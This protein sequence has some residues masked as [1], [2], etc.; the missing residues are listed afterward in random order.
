MRLIYQ[1]NKRLVVKLTNTSSP[2]QINASTMPAK[3]TSTT[4]YGSSSTKKRTR[5]S[6][7]SFGSIQLREHERVLAGN[8]STNTYMG[9]AIGWNYQQQEPVSVAEYEQAKKKTIAAERTTAHQRLTILNTYG[10]SLQEVRRC[11]KERKQLRQL[12]ED[13]EKKNHARGG[14][15]SRFRRHFL[16][17]NQRRGE[18]HTLQ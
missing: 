8:D 15:F 7:V 6:V 16:L 14:R 9:L 4:T 5:P 11:E 12:E 17:R 13:G 1:A 3:A 10:F 2:D 18:V